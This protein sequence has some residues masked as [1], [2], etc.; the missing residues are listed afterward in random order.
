MQSY[1]RAAAVG[2]YEKALAVTVL[3]LKTIPHLSSKAAEHLKDTFR[4]SQINA[5]LIVPV[6]LS[7]RRRHE[8][9]F[10]QAEVLAQIVKK[11][12]GIPVD[13]AS[14]LRTVH[15][16]AHRAGMDAKARERT[17]KNA[18]VVKRKNLI[19]GK[20]IL[21]I[22]DVFTTGSTVSAC[23]KVLKKNGAGKVFVLTLARAH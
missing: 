20:N 14:L 13:A 2:L 7:K 12:S 8:R 4:S 16:A 23:A 6:P 18:F 17:V 21:I 5:D 10:N 9:G 15:T 19:E 22:D 1:E 3:Q 11:S